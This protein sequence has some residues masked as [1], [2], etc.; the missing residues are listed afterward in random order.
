MNPAAPRRGAIDQDAAVQA[1]P[2]DPRPAG[3][4]GSADLG[5]HDR[6]QDHRIQG[7]QIIR[8][9]RLTRWVLDSRGLDRPGGPRDNRIRW[10]QG[11]P[12]IWG[13]PG[14]SL[15]PLGL[16]QGSGA[17]D[18]KRSFR[19]G[20]A[21]DRVLFERHLFSGFSKTDPLRQKDQLSPAHDLPQKLHPGGRVYPDANIC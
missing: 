10:V 4:R 13:I 21:K 20:E 3:S 11:F 7:V 19:A 16:N 12:R 5:A 8:G 15:D 9:G 2:A 14:N 1:L 17:D 18:D 6:A